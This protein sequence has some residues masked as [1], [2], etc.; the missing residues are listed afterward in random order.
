MTT[1]HF[2]YAVL[3]SRSGSAKGSPTRLPKP[4]TNPASGPVRLRIKRKTI[5]PATMVVTTG[6]K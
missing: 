3:P 2:E 4:L 1:D 6:R 5:A